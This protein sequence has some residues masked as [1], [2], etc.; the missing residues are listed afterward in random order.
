MLK[1]LEAL[2]A[3]TPE[4]VWAVIQGTQDGTITGPVL[5]VVTFQDEQGR[6]LHAIFA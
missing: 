1:S 6:T 4:Q 2:E 3:L 5:L